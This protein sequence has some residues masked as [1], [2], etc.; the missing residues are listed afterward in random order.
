MVYFITYPL[1]NIHS[2]YW[3]TE[4]CATPADRFMVL[5][6]ALFEADYIDYFIWEVIK[7]NV[8]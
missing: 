8:T 3:S 7:Q 5:L 2:S 4:G 1:K 6:K